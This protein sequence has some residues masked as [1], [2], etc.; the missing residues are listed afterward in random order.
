[1]SGKLHG[2]RFATVPEWVLDADVSDRALRLFAVLARYA[3]KEGR[4]FPS[5]RTLA[6]RLRC[7]PASL[8]RALAELA[9]VDALVVVPQSRADGG[10]SSNSYYLWP[11]QPPEQ[12]SL[13]VTGDEAP[14]HGRAGPVVT[15]DE[16]AVV[17]GDEGKKNES[18]CERKPVERP[19]ASAAST[20]AERGRRIAAAVWDARKAAGQ[21]TP[22][23]PFVA[24]AKIAERFDS[25]DERAVVAA[26]LAV[27]TISTGWV[28]GELR[29]HARRRAPAALVAER[30]KRESGRVA[31]L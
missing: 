12:L 9:A 18:Q 21:S 16:G 31:D 20:S 29:R 24:V 2:H 7:S 22:A 8:D 23:Q 1:M 25:Y 5:R 28:E 13:V 6:E 19:A 15:G 27:P 26:M 17:T 14:T 3:D 30:G 11:A 4:A 10:R